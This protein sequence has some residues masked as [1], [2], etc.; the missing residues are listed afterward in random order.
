MASRGHAEP[1]HRVNLHVDHAQELEAALPQLDSPQSENL[2]QQ[3]QPRRPSRLVELD[4]FELAL[5]HGAAEN[6]GRSPL[7]RILYDQAR[8]RAAQH[9]QAMRR[10]GARTSGATAKAAFQS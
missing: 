5:V 2:A 8:A 4:G 9:E 10:S 6:I 3:K 7:E 1:H